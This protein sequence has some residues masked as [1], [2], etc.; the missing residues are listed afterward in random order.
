MLQCRSTIRV[1]VEDIEDP[2][3]RDML[4]DL[5]EKQLVRLTWDL[6]NA[7]LVGC[8]ASF[9]SGIANCSKYRPESQ[10]S[11]T[12]SPGCFLGKYSGMSTL[13][14]QLCTQEDCYN[15]T[16]QQPWAST[17]FVPIARICVLLL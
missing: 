11:L 12:M 13:L 7:I 17:T 16:A 15:S 8:F 14:L 10:S 2:V 3:E 6:G 1:A 5:R 9:V 4:K